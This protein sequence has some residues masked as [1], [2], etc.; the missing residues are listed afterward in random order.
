MNTYTIYGLLAVVIIILAGVS[1]YLYT[2]PKARKELEDEGKKVITEGETIA[3][4]IEKIEPQINEGINVAEKILPA[5]YVNVIEEIRNLA[6]VGSKYAQQLYKTEQLTAGQRYD[7]A[8]AVVTTGL[9]KLGI[10][11][12]ESTASLIKA[13]IEGAVNDLPSIPKDIKEVRDEL[14]KTKADLLSSTTTVSQLEVDKKNA[15]A[16][17]ETISK[18]KDSI[19]TQLKSIKGAVGALTDE[20]VS[21]PVANNT[22]TETVTQ[23]VNPAQ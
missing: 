13:S 12:D 14:E 2:H 15:L 22:T 7:A 21:T 9:S 5:K 4:N 16:T 18:E 11:V 1:I 3:K 20:K 23:P 6:I 19:A 10:D 8:E 17:I